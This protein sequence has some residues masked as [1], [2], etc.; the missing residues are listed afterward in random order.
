MTSCSNTTKI[1]Q[2]AQTLIGT[3]ISRFEIGMQKEK[4]SEC[5]ELSDWELEQTLQ[6]H[7]MNVAQ[8]SGGT[9]FMM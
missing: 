1:C 5:C 7:C 4:H 3:V 8:D 2:K 9:K 6:H